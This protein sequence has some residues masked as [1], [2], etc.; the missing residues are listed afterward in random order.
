MSDFKPDI[1]RLQ[2]QSDVNGLVEALHNDDATIR[3]RAATALRALGAVEVISVLEDLLKSESDSETREHMLAALEALQNELELQAAENQPRN[4]EMTEIEYLINQLDSR[5]PATVMEAAHALGELEDKLAVPALV[6][7]FNDA[8][9]SIKVRLAVAEAL[10]KLESAPVEVALLGALR[11]GGWRVR[12]NGA[13]ILGQ[14][15]AEWAIEPLAKALF[16]DHE[17]VR[18]TAYAALRHIGT[19]EAKIALSRAR[20]MAERKQKPAPTV[21]DTSENNA[22]LNAEDDTPLSGRE[23]DEQAPMQ[24][25]ETNDDT[26]DKITWP[27]KR[28]PINPTMAPTKPFDPE[29][30]ERARQQIEEHKRR[31]QSEDENED[32]E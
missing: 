6:S 12:R 17:L 7:L 8:R 10:L 30:I 16:D 11:S 28:K 25:E 19:K 24:P 13:A 21:T 5:D 29:M 4:L 14:L 1:W 27:S 22:L 9:I 20:K 18:R 23:A 26:D 31:S 2:A 15:R 3:R 32:E